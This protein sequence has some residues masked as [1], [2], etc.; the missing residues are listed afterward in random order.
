MRRFG[1]VLVLAH[2]LFGYTKWVGADETQLALREESASDDIANVFGGFKDD[3]NS[4]QV[5]ELRGWSAN[6]DT[7]YAGPPVKFEGMNCASLAAPSGN[8]SWDSYLSYLTSGGP[9]YRLSAQIS[10]T[11]VIQDVWFE[12]SQD[13]GI[14]SGS[15]YQTY[16]AIQEEGDGSNVYYADIGD[17][18]SG[19]YSWRVKVQVPSSSGRRRSPRSSYYFSPEYTFDVTPG[20]CR[21]PDL[22]HVFVWITRVSTYQYRYSLSFIQWSTRTY[23]GAN[24]CTNS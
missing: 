18:E 7:G 22:S 4:H 12:V 11:S 24:N 20:M 15:P 10:S 2:L 8:N 13:G 17:L 21:V 3:D 6:P 1:S 16:D 23:R 19:A 5:R 14:A 9:V